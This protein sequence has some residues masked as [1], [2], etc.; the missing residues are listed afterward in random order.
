MGLF[1]QALV[2]GLLMGGVYAAYSSGFSLIFGVMNIVNIFHGELIM[3]G[4]FTTYWLYTLYHID[5]FLTLPFSIISAGVIGYVIQRFVINRVVEAP[6]MMSYLCTFGIHLILGQPG[7]PALERRFQ[8]RHHELLRRGFFP[9]PRYHTDRAPRHLPHRHLHDLRRLPVPGK[10][11]V[12]EGHPRGKPGQGN[13]ASRGHRHQEGVRPHLCHRRRDHRSC[14]RPHLHALCHLSPDGTPLHDHRL[15]RRR[16]RRDG[17]HPRRAGRR[18]APGRHPIAHRDLP[19]VRSFHCHNLYSAL[20]YPRAE[21]DRASW[22]RGS[23]NE[24]ARR[25]DRRLLCPPSSF[26]H[27]GSKATTTGRSR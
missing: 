25:L 15:L 2:T 27:S 10:G 18:P 5:P 6:P 23:S 16:A 22:A 7:A 3:I 12:R 24:E 26:P 19:D 20:R 14:R 21:A 9:G 17:L 1:I 11:P 8:D 4:A 13:G